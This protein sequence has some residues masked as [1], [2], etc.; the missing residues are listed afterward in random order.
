M[1]QTD[2]EKARA[3]DDRDSWK[4]VSI[5]STNLGG[6]LSAVAG[7]GGMTALGLAAGGPVFVVCA[8]T[9]IVLRT[10][11]EL[12]GVEASRKLED[13]PRAD[14]QHETSVQTVLNY[15]DAFGDSDLERAIASFSRATIEAVSLESAM[16]T[17]FERE[18][19]AL[20]YGA[21]EYVQLRATERYGLQLAAGR[22]NLQLAFVTR[23]LADRFAA[24]VLG[25]S[26]FRQ[27]SGQISHERIQAA[28]EGRDLFT[29]D[30][31][32]FPEERAALQVAGYPT[33]S[34]GHA[35]L[36]FEA[37]S[38]FQA[39]VSLLKHLLHAADASA[40]YGRFLLGGK[41]PEG[42]L[43][44]PVTPRAPEPYGPSG[45]WVMAEDLIPL[46]ELL[47]RLVGS[48]WRSGSP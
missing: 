36:D 41:P 3:K 23:V 26:E 42:G 7:L 12:K 19:G 20:L 45:D 13:P 24:D 28:A 14:F 4:R 1:A 16:V 17:A 48:R 18:S 27:V 44:T 30:A 11:A 29:I 9:T 31:G 25:D 2:E 22:S 6:G 34:L 32:A 15:R 47:L 38:L 40:A 37:G 39:A 5:W 33:S 43:P 8:L 46:I 10:N 21:D 35:R